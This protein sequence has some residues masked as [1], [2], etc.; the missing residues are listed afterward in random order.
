VKLLLIRHA[1]AGERD[2]ERWPDDT[3]RPLTGKGE[4]RHAKVARRLA[5]KGC[6]PSLLLTSPWRRAWQ[7]AEITAEELNSPAPIATDTLASPPSLGRI[8][9]AIGARKEDAVVLLVGHEPW[10][11]ELAARLLTGQ[12]NGMNIDFPKSG[13]LGLSLE[14]VKPGAATLEFF[15]RPKPD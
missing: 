9:S 13:V 11:S 1:D 8:A 7:T 3:Q 14:Q 5:R 15:L 6:R 4:K 10:M 2:P 12:P